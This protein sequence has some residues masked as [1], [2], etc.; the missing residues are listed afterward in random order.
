MSVQLKIYI[1]LAKK[2]NKCICFKW[3]RLK[4]DISEPSSL[5]GS[6]GTSSW[7][8]LLVQIRASQVVLV[9]KNPLAKAGNMRDVSSIPESGRSSG[10][11]DG[12]PLQYSSLGNPM[13][14]EAWWA[15]IDTVAKS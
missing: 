1:F 3:K 10:G 14:R 4:A 6:L 7:E 9:I 5:Q 12:N 2:E 11:G 8:Q 15:T 13:D